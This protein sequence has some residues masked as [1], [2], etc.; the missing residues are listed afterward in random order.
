MPRFSGG[1]SSFRIAWALGC[2]PPPVRPWIARNRISP[3]RLG[4]R[5]QSSELAL[6]PMMQAMKKRL[7]PSTVESQP[8]AGR[9]MA[10]VTR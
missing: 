7:R 5:P 2:R 9:M 4:A 1:A 3:P 6:K 10:L 8:L